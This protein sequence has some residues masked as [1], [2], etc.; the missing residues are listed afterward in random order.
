MRGEYALLCQ[1]TGAALRYHR[2]LV[3]LCLDD[4]ASTAGVPQKRVPRL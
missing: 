2:E 3:G 1:V 4:A